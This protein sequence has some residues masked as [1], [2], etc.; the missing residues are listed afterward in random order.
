[1]PAACELGA[2]TYWLAVSVDVDFGVG[3]QIFWS[4]RT[5]QSNAL[6][7]W[8]NPGD[9]FASGCT[10]W[11]T[12]PSCGVGGG[13]DPDVLFQILGTEGG[14]GVPAA[15]PRELPTLSQWGVLFGAAGL[16][17]LGMLRVRRRNQF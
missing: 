8:R 16:A 17:L 12:I 13:V 15:P 5:V 2:G 14:G 9:G 1:L 10:D 3:G 6:A 4:T 7:A 11:G